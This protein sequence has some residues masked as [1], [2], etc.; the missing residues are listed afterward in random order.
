MYDLNQDG[1]LDGIEIMKS[2]THAHGGGMFYFDIFIIK[3]FFC[4]VGH[5]VSH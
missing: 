4:D 1:K 3:T 2:L 5:F